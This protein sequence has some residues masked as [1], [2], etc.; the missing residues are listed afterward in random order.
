MDNSGLTRFESLAA[1]WSTSKMIAERLEL[2]REDRKRRRLTP[3][4]AN[5][6]H[7]SSC[8][9]DWNFGV[10]HQANCKKRHRCSAQTRAGEVCMGKH[11]AVQHLGEE[12]NYNARK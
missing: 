10:C 6:G 12:R 9:L 11:R 2:Q 5:A 1:R 4:P 7:N 8:C 3:A